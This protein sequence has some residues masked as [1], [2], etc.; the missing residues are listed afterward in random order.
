MEIKTLFHS[1]K[2]FYKAFFS[3]FND[4]EN[5]KFAWEIV[6][7]PESFPCIVVKSCGNYF[8]VYPKDFEKK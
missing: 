4:A 8:F 6:S 2:E 3:Q 1:N 7:K 5:A